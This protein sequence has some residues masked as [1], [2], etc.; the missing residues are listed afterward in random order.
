[1]ETKE[2]K[3]CY[4]VIPID[5]F[6]KGK[7][8]CKACRNSQ[9]TDKYIKEKRT[10]LRN[11]FTED[12]LNNGCTLEEFNRMFIKYEDFQDIKHNPNYSFA[13]SDYFK[14]F[15]PKDDYKGGY[16]LDCVMCGTS[17]SKCLNKIVFII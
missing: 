17:P 16:V 9:R 14:G 5:C 3:N 12:F 7:A 8:I 11:E 1:M 4:S 10:K 13:Y 15:I 2:C 6:T